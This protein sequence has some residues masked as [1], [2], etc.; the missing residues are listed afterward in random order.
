M[1]EVYVLGEVSSPGVLTHT[2]DATALRAI[3]S[4]GG[5]TGKAW[6]QKV[7]VIRGSLNEPQTFIVNVTDVLSARSGDFALQPRDIVFV[8]HRPWI[9]AEELLDAA[10]SAFVQ[11]AVIVWTGGNVGPILR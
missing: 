9:K 8:S 3:A 1:K 7:L 5:F 6:R 11:G 10:A 4:R 2:P